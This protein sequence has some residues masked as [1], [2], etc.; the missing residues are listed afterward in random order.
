M[1][2]KGAKRLRSPFDDVRS[3]PRPA[4]H[5]DLHA[6]RVYLAAN[7]I[8]GALSRVASRRRDSHTFRQL[9]L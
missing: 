2:R 5:D 3:F 8:L 1:K 6:R 7:A 4:L 9:N